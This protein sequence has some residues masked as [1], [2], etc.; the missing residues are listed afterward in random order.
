[1]PA[2]VVSVIATESDAWGGVISVT[3]S[4]VAGSFGIRNKSTGE[5]A[6]PAGTPLVNISDGVWEYELAKDDGQ[7]YEC[8]ILIEHADGQLRVFQDVFAA[9]APVE[10]SVSDSA[11][12]STPV[13]GVNLVKQPLERVFV[14]DRGEY[15]RLQ[16]AAE[17]EV[18]MPNQIFSFQKRPDNPH[19]QVEGQ[20][21][22]LFIATPFDVTIYPVGSKDAEQVPG[23]YRKSS[24]DVLVASTEIAKFIIDSVDRDVAGLIANYNRLDTLFPS[25]ETILDGSGAFTDVAISVVPPPADESVVCPAVELDDSAVLAAEL[26]VANA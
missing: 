4:N 23:F 26:V 20:E 21:E 9:E 15:L 17:D 1:M 16:I 12:D 7:I 5:V 18:L 2:A 11:S 3:L 13:R 25:A 22:F 14:P 6:V 24:L 19:D 8:A 10:V